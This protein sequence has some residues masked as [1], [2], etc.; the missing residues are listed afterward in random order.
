MGEVN[1]YALGQWDALTLFLTDAHLP[2]RGPRKIDSLTTT[3][4]MPPAA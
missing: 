1:G 3:P 2:P 4:S